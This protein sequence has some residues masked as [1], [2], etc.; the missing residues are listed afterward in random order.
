MLRVYCLR[1]LAWGFERVWGTVWHFKGHSEYQVAI[2]SE[3]A[4]VL[5]LPRNHNCF[6]IPGPQGPGVEFRGLFRILIL[7][8][9]GL[10]LSVM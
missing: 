2:G 1:F 10:G 5:S 6:T 8:I 4:L 7:R 3:S 9:L